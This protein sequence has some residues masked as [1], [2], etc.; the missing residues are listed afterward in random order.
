MFRV[1]YFQCLLTSIVRKM[2]WNQFS[3]SVLLTSNT[4]TEKCISK[5][6]VR[7]SS[8]L[9]SLIHFKVFWSGFIFCLFFIICCPSFFVLFGDLFLTVMWATFLVK[10]M[11]SLENHG[12]ICCFYLWERAG[13]VN[14]LI[15]G[16]PSELEVINILNGFFTGWAEWPF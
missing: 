10:A 2:S 7:R 11:G 16:I 14:F 8:F 12:N 9:K 13:G 3:C 6:H 5:H 15:L 4:D 1:L